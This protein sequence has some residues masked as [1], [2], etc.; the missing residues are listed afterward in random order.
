ME[1][2]SCQPNVTPK[3]DPHLSSVP[4]GCTAH[5]WHGR[6]RLTG[7]PRGGLLRMLDVAMM[8]SFVTAAR[9]RAALGKARRRRVCTRKYLLIRLWP[10]S[11]AAASHV[12]ILGM[13]RRRS[14]AAA[15]GRGRGQKPRIKGQLMRF[16]GAASERLC[17]AMP[18]Q[19]LRGGGGGKSRQGKRVQAGRRRVREVRTKPA[20]A[21]ASRQAAWQA[22]PWA[23]P[24]SALGVWAGSSRL[25]RWDATAQQNDVHRWWLGTVAGSRRESQA[26]RLHSVLCR[27]SF[28]EG[29]PTKR[30]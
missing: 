27:A 8:N 7:P 10:G 4:H 24:E 30:K 2:S 5:T 21:A 11:R 12:S 19:A 25:R 17:S 28:C 26:A 16:R 23:R 14:R 29:V 13:L 20:K 6:S 22:V 3:G 18:H 1:R 15:R 9:C